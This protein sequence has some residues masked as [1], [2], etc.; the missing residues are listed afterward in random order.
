MK[1]EFNT[2]GNISIKNDRQII[3]TNTECIMYK[4]VI[5]RDINASFNILKKGLEKWNKENS[6]NIIYQ[7]VLIFMRDTKRTISFTKV[8][9]ENKKEKKL[10][11]IENKKTSSTKK[12]NPY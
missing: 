1:T 10:K 8:I 9:K 3:C 5:N 4:K 12:E 7:N 6:H 2:V 11:E